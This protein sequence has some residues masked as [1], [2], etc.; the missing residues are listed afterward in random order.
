MRT[1]SLFLAVTASLIVGCNPAL[2]GKKLEEA[3]SKKLKD[4]KYPVASVTCP[5]SQPI[6]KDATLVCEAKFDGDTSV[7]IDV[8]QT[9][10]GNVEWDAKGVLLVADFAKIVDKKTKES[11]PSAEVSCSGKPVIVVK[12]DVTLKCAVKTAAGSSDYVITFSDDKGAWDAKSVGDD[13]KPEPAKQAAA[14]PAEEP[15]AGEEP[16][17]SGE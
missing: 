8:K 5:A 16:K 14:S 2:D 17:P 9:G 4:D 6:Q 13:K 7:S 11:D 12:K 1:L 10:E 3:I 15:K